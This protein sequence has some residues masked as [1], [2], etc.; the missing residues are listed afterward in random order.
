MLTHLYLAFAQI[1]HNPFNLLLIF[2]GAFGGVIIGAIPGLTAMMAVALL[3]PITF[4]MEMVPAISMLIG[5]YVGAISGGFISAALLNIP[6]TPSSVATTFDAYPMVR[7][8]EHEKA[9]GIA[10]FA[11]FFGSMASGAVLIFIAPN[12]ARFALKF[13]PFEY[14]SLVL[15][16]SCCVTSF[17][18]GS[19]VKAFFAVFFGMTLGMMGTSPI[20]QVDRFTFGID[21]LAGGF[22]VLPVLI[23]I[24]ALPQII[25]DIQTPFKDT[26]D[27]KLY[28]IRIG[29]IIRSISYFKASAVNM[30][31]T[32]AIGIGIGILP[33]VGPG[34]SNIVSYSQAKSASKVPETFGK[35]AP[36]GVIAAEGANNASMGGALIPLLTLGIP[37]DGVTLLMLGAFML[38]GIQ[39]GPLMFKNNPDVMYAIFISFLSASVIVC[40][41]QMLFMKFYVRVLSVKKQYLIPV[42]LVLCIVGCYSANSR[43]FDVWTFFGFGILGYL[44]EM[45]AIPILPM[46]LGYILGPMAEWHLRSGLDLSGGRLWPLFTRPIPA[47]FIAATIF[48]LLLPLIRKQFKGWRPTPTPIKGENK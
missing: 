20:L 40:L 19:L 27:S 6:G 24:F 5:V 34:L 43:M 18:K 16:T 25:K 15:F 28:E 13:G 47:F 8:G 2:G 39:P 21:E 31:R 32:A 37:G 44:F 12:L 45:L 11:S 30:I 36:D 29:R 17:A 26:R 23:G 22:A 41:L 9:L 4:G 33:G 3:V 46:I 48:T 7:K 14:L 10:L 38:H 42:L 35:G 1:F